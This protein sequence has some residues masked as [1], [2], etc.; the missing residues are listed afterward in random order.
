[1]DLDQHTT[2][3]RFER[4]VKR[5]RRPAGISVRLEGFSPLAMLIVSNRQVAGEQEHFFPIFVNE[6]RCRVDAWREAKQ[7]GPT[8][9]LFGL[10]ERSRQDFLLNTRG[11][12]SRS[13]PSLRHV[14]GME[15]FVDLVDS[16][17]NS[18]RRVWRPLGW[19]K[20]ARS[21]TSHAGEIITGEN[22]VEARRCCVPVRRGRPASRRSSQVRSGDSN[23]KAAPE[24]QICCCPLLS[25]VR[26]RGRPEV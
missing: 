25:E 22:P 6:R 7:A 26:V 18:P 19:W 5:A 10:V 23:R 2:G 20:S 13:F 24:T 8:A 3:F 4:T 9:A 12:S 17:W 14:E 15:F 21:C 16:H 11:I 1:M